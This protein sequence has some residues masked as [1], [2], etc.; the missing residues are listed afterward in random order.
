MLNHTKELRGTTVDNSMKMSE[1][2]TIPFILHI[3]FNNTVTVNYLNNTS[4]L[5]C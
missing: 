5:V 1:L 4:I 3:S 2:Q